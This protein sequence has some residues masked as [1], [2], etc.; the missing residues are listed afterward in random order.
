MHDGLSRK[1]KKRRISNFIVRVEKKSTNFCFFVFQ[2]LSKL[3]VGAALLAHL[4]LNTPNICAWF[5]TKTVVVVA[6]VGG[7]HLK[8]PRQKD[9]VQ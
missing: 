9:I 1:T 5:S 2:T 8:P 6:A 4:R 7:D 3:V